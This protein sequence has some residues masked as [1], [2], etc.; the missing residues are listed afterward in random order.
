MNKLVKNFY[1]YTNIPFS[2]S[3]SFFVSFSVGAW[4][5]L[6]VCLTRSFF[7]SFYIRENYIYILHSLAEHLR[8]SHNRAYPSSSILSL[9]PFWGLWGGNGNC[10]T[11]HFR[12]ITSIAVQTGIQKNMYMKK[13]THSFMLPSRDICTLSDSM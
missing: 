8:T 11:L 10:L 3:F 2:F 9:P 13:Y 7:I 5:F 1:S 6:F 12:D 4:V